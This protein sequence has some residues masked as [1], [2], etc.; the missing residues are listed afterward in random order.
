MK[1]RFFIPCIFFMI[2]LLSSCSDNT[3]TPQT[4]GSIEGKVINAKTMEPISGALIT[5]QPVSNSILSENDGSFVFPDLEEGE[6]IVD[7]KKIGFNPNYVSVRVVK[8]KAAK[9]TILLYD[10]ETM[11]TAPEIPVA[12]APSDKDEIGE[13]KVLIEWTCSDKD[14]D[15]LKYDVFLSKQNPP[16]NL[17][18]QGISE[19]SY[20]T[21]NLDTA[22]TYYWKIIAKDNFTYSESRVYSFTVNKSSV[23]PSTD[24]ILHYT[25]DESNAFDVSGNGNSGTLKNNPQF[26]NGKK[27]LAARLIGTS[28]L[29]GTGSHILIPD[30]YFKSF[31]GFTIALWVNEESLQYSAGEAY[32]NWGNASTGWVGIS[33]FMKPPENTTLVL[34]YSVGCEAY[35][36]YE[37]QQ[38]VWV[39]YDISN[40]N[41]WIHYALVYSNGTTKGYING[42]RIGTATHTINTIE[43]LGA[44]GKHW[45]NYNGTHS[46][47]SMTFSVDEVRVYK[48]ALTDNEINLLAK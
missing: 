14:D 3:S 38:P 16:T 44:I 24:L 2:A 35:N 43:P 12:V 5:T 8:G 7:A 9:A 13:T 42:L 1:N 41:K 15:K 27:G 30:I 17:L 19:T 34:N 39:T 40:R 46:A 20:L 45:W 48:K 25:F 37:R 10:L 36:Y 28:D 33:N 6:Y 47:T 4:N 23:L 32:I 31:N 18:V 11:N 21:E 22:A 26:V 29:L